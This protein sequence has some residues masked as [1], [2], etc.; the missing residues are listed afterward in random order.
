MIV[1]RQTPIL[2]YWSQSDTSS[3]DQIVN[4]LNGQL[5]KIAPMCK[6]FGSGW[7]GPTEVTSYGYGGLAE[8]KTRPA[9]IKGTCNAYKE[10]KEPQT[11]AD[12]FIFRSKYYS[13][14]VESTDNYE[15]N[16]ISYASFRVLRSDEVTR[17]K[18]SMHTEGRRLIVDNIEDK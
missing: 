6:P 12:K 18:V 17:G 13:I 15:G 1:A 2:D 16:I 8:Y 7:A 14:I 3:Y 5:Q 4:N 9:C 10:C 11:D